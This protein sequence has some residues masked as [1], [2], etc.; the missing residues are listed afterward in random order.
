MTAG[1]EGGGFGRV[2]S[3]SAPCRRSRSTKVGLEP[4]FVDIRPAHRLEIDELR[5]NP[6]PSMP[7]LTFGGAAANAGRRTPNAS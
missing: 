1:I 4:S 6:P 3:I 5:P 2:S 7:P